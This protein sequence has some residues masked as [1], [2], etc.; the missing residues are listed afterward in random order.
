[1]A[2]KINDLQGFY[3]AVETEVLT[4]MKGAVAMW[5]KDK[6]ISMFIGDRIMALKTDEIN[7]CDY[8]EKGSA[9]KAVELRVKS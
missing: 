6:A 9:F 3:I 2:D 7:E 4:S 5:G 1:M 8:I